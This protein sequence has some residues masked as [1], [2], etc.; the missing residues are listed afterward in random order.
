MVRTDFKVWRSRYL[1][2]VGAALAA[3]ALPGTASA[4]KPGTHVASSN[5]VIDQLGPVITLTPGTNSSDTLVFE[6]N[7]QR[8]EVRVT[9]RDAYRAI[10]NNQDFYRAG[11]VGP[12]GF[13]DP[14]T[15][16][17]LAHG[18]GSEP[19]AKFIK[20]AT[21]REVPVHEPDV[22]YSDRGGAA[23]FRAIDFPMA[24]LDFLATDYSA[25]PEHDQILAFILG[26]LSHGIGDGF[27][28][29]WVNELAGGAWELT[30]GEGIFGVPSEEIKHVTVEAYVDSLVPEAL[31]SVPGDSGGHMRIRLAA[32]VG[33]LDDFYSRRTPNAVMLGDRLGDTNQ[34]FD[35][36]ANL[37]QHFGGFFYN[38][39]NAQV[40]LYPTLVRWS[41]LGD[42]FSTAEKVRDNEFVNFGLDAAELPA[43]IINEL[44][45]YGPEAWLDE[46][47]GGYIDCYTETFGSETWVDEI[48]YAL[49]FLGGV[50][51]R[52]EKLSDKAK[53][54]RKNWILLN[55]CTS[56]NLAKLQAAAFDP[57]NPAV[58]TDACADIARAGW[59]EDGQPGIYRG[60]I[61]PSGERDQEFLTELK[62][63]FLGGDAD[64]IF[65]GV[66][67]P[68]EAGAPYNTDKAIEET[69][70]HR[71]MR[72]N[73]ER[74]F[75]YVTGVALTAIHIDQAIFPEGDGEQDRVNDYC[76]AA[77]DE[78][79]ERCLDIKFA[80][81][82]AP[83]RQIACDIEFASCAADEAL[84]CAQSA[85]HAACGFPLSDS[86]CNSICGGEPSGCH[87]DCDD[88]FTACA[89]DICV[90]IPVLYESCHL[91]CLLFGD[92]EESC[93]DTII[94]TGI[95]GG[96]HFVCTVE[97][98]EATITLD[99]YAE[100][101]LTPVR[102]ACDAI[103]AAKAFARCIKGDP[104]KSDEENRAA[105]RVCLIDACTEAEC[106]EPGCSAAERDA[107]RAKCTN[108]Y[109][110]TM[111][112]YDEAKRIKEEIAEVL[113]ILRDRPPHELVNLAFLEEDLLQDPDYFTEL[114]DVL[115]DTRNQ[116][117]AEPPSPERT[118]KIN[119]LNRF[120]QLLTD[121]DTIRSGGSPSGTGDP[122]LDLR[123]ATEDA[124]N[125]LTDAAELGLI[126]TVIGPTARRILG[127]VG[128]SFTQTFDQFF[129]TAQGMK[130]APLTSQ[131]DMEAMFAAPIDSSLLPWTGGTGFS[132]FCS[133]SASNPFC[134]VLAS[135]DDPNCMN[136]DSTTRKMNPQPPHG[137]IP[138][139]NL[140]AWNEY[141]PTQEKHH[142]LTR[143]MFSTSD[144]AYEEL[145]TKIFRVPSHVPGFTGFDDPDA[146]W[147]VDNGRT[148]VEL[149]TNH[150]NYTEGSG[151]LQVNG[152]GYI[153][154]ASPLHKTADWGIVG[155]QIQ[156][157]IFVPEA[158][159]NPWHVGDVQFA[160]SIAGA[161]QF[162]QYFGYRSLNNLPRGEWSTLT[163]DVPPHILDA[164]LGD[165][166]DFKLEIILNIASCQE[167]VLID[168]LRFAGTIHEREAFHI[169]GSSSY[170]VTSNSLFGFENVSDW[171]SSTTLGSVT[172]RTQG[173]AALSVAANNYTPI[174]SRAFSTS[175]LTGV[176]NQL[177]LDVKIPSPPSSEYW[178]GDVSLSF[179]CGP[180]SNA[181][182]G[183]AL[184]T[185]KFRGEYNSFRFTLPPEVVSALQ[186][187]H[188]GC[189][190]AVNLNSGPGV[191]FLLDNMGFI[192]E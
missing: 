96:E 178:F 75:D 32:P 158:Q 139:R 116:V 94:S 180:V 90:P 126:P 19:V 163:F 162:N 140:I 151:S 66:S 93:T 81:I 41:T 103:D 142:V 99:N 40:D 65:E 167:P 133:G 143:F 67:Q 46:L 95:C 55:Q 82:A 152:C 86:E 60:N 85:C 70:L 105:R 28:H 160:A 118:R 31:R 71:S 63:S 136:C 110:E 58:N 13:P 78:A 107:A 148:D 191:T 124:K 80:I 73:L 179:T 91:Y 134:D 47:T 120:D 157:D 7:G 115:Q 3:L 187:N 29:E 52:V 186:G 189:T 121:V 72:A 6:V 69:N 165:Y 175:E 56:E 45:Q 21:G 14:L 77:R 64:D 48:R 177:N 50:E 138:G 135:F 102:E 108:T 61:A 39:F 137:W 170:T 169:R 35:Y 42:F 25:S 173:A 174:T 161:N 132:S 49:E 104:A 141:D 37:D 149:E 38:Y 106:F 127:D 192:S 184:L 33:F 183:P 154:L 12:D 101:L 15:G 11:V 168:N 27:A 17:L 125:I 83:A 128:P 84:D 109:D 190:V 119:T 146:P 59:V 144:S 112:V 114:E 16:Q 92:G 51:D 185:Y 97:N 131:T 18:D 8:L 166:A 54:V 182:V 36:Y 111:A 30:K 87:S 76:T 23:E 113:D 164:W 22:P 62:A 150:T 159:A 181:Y 9:G 88:M 68:W 79:F 34:F 2:S 129:N 117:M 1:L 20:N 176:T 130:L 153:E 43:E 171:G 10:L 145:Y 188:S 123:N 57:D 4:F 44:T 172:E 24:M 98:F 155:E 147:T 26:Y 53:L 5:H 156:F 100:E 74:L 89:F 122:L